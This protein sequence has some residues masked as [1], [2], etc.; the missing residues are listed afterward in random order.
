[1]QSE[2]HETLY[3]RLSDIAVRVKATLGEDDAETLAGLA[4]EHSEV[5][6]KLSRAGISQDPG[7]LEM[8]KKTHDQ[9]NLVIAEIRR[10]RNELSRQLVMFGKK[11][12]VSGAYARNMALR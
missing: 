6:D 8:A 11:K 9:V 3:R 5:M 4:G 12:R 7:L 10:Q 1:L 2:T